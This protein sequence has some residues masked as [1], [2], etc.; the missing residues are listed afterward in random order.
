MLTITAAPSHPAGSSPDAINAGPYSRQNVIAT[1]YNGEIYSR[2]VFSPPL[3]YQPERSS[4]TEER[5]NHSNIA[6][7]RPA[8]PLL[9]SR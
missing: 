8:V 6:P 4:D 7:R 3:L 9:S 2:I 1:D 5:E